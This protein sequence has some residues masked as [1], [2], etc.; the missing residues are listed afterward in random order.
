MSQAMIQ[1]EQI[2]QVEENARARF[3][4]R[5]EEEGRNPRALGWDT[6]ESMHTRFRAATEIYDFT[7]TH[8]LD[9]GCGFGDFLG[10]LESIG[11][12]PA[13]YV[14]TDISDAILDIAREKHP[15]AMFDN[16]NVLIDPYADREFDV[17]VEFGVLNYNLD[18]MSNKAYFRHFLQQ[19]YQQSDAVLLNALSR[20]REGD[21]DYEESVHYYDPG[22][23]F[24]YAQEL[25]HDVILQHDFD[26]IP[27]KEF[28]LLVK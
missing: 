8:V 15:D 25:S 5:L 7:D 3:E 19:A 9:V 20:H 26:P 11:Q 27:Q 10:F 14:G 13:S 16:R 28:N 22:T 6:E 24:G 18:N 4:D 12:P 17:I 21:W 23:V 1:R 2:R